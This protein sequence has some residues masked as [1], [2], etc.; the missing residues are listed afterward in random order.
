MYQIPFQLRRDFLFLDMKQLITLL[1]TSLLVSSMAQ[2]ATI[3]GNRELKE[4][5]RM[6]SAQAIQ[7][8]HDGS[9]WVRLNTRSAQIA[10]YRK[11]GNNSAADKVE[12]EVR[13]LNQTIV[14]AFTAKFSFC[15]VYFFADTFSRCIVEGRIADV[16]FYNA[17]LQPDPAIHPPN[18]PFFISEYGATRSDN[19]PAFRNDYTYDA[20]EEGA[21]KSTR[22]YT[23]G[24]MG[25][26]AFVIMDSTFNQLTDPFPYYQRF[27][28]RKINRDKIDD[29]I[30]RLS[31]KLTKYYGPG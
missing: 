25:L 24:N 18:V 5:E 4:Q 29:K 21:Q 30:L 26:P 15:P 10:Y 22:Y 28:Y 20:S 3:N 27:T 1:F 2:N 8:L 12:A 17:S 13:L 6:R 9:L 16:V 7:Q 31:E 11:H 14:D 23:T 19:E